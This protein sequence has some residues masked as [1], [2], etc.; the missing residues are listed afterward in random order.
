MKKITLLF[1]ITLSSL[2]YA[3]E[4]ENAENIDIIKIAK[5]QSNISENILEKYLFQ[6]TLDLSDE[7]EK[8][9]VLFQQ[10]LNLLVEYSKNHN[11]KLQKEVIEKGLNTWSK[12]K[13]ITEQPISDENI[14]KI[15]QLS[16]DLLIINEE[17]S[18]VSEKIII[19]NIDSSISSI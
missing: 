13:N 2:F 8:E 1:F 10:N 16:A 4:T 17:F 3:N 11:N 19:K 5:S 18:I 14:E 15:I 7:M 6:E 12:F 9:K